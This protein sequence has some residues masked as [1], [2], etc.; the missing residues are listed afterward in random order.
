MPTFIRNYVSTTKSKPAEKPVSNEAYG[1]KPMLSTRQLSE[2]LGVSMNT[3]RTLV[4]ESDD[5]P[6]PTKVGRQFR[7][8]PIEVKEWLKRHQEKKR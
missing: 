5:F 4:A 3:I 2:V 6:R 7:F 8:C 1:L